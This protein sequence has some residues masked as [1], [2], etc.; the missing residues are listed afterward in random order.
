MF[1]SPTL[2]DRTAPP[3]DVYIALCTMWLFAALAWMVGACCTQLP[4]P[5]LD[6]VRPTL[7]PAK[8]TEVAQTEV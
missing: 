6:P 2:P 1:M 8:R 3:F 4:T 7:H 5:V